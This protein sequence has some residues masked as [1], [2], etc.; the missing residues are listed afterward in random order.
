MEFYEGHS[1]C[2]VKTN[3]TGVKT[4]SRGVVIIHPVADDEIHHERVVRASANHGLPPTKDKTGIL[5]YR[6]MQH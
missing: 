5:C 4:A 6:C 3:I 2:L 1:I